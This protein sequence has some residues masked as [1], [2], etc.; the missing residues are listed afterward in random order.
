MGKEICLWC[1]GDVTGEYEGTLCP[2]C[3]QRLHKVKVEK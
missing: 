1:G 3:Y 2:H